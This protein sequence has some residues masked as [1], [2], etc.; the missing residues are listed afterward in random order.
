M[1]QEIIF[2]S[3]NDIKAFPGCEGFG[4]EATGGR[5]SSVV[6]FVTN[7][8]NGGAGSTEQA[9]NNQRASGGRIILRAAGTVDHTNI[10]YIGQSN[11]QASNLTYYG[12]SA[13]YQGLQLRASATTGDRKEI[14]VVGSNQI[15]RHLKSTDAGQGTHTADAM[16]IGWPTG[17]H[18]MEN[19]VLDHVS[20][21]GARSRTLSLSTKG[22]SNDYTPPGTYLRKLTISNSLLSEPIPDAPMQIIMYG[23]NQSEIS[24]IKNIL[25]NAKERHPLSNAVGAQVEWLNNYAYNNWSAHG[26]HPGSKWDIISNVWEQGPV[27]NTSGTN[28]IRLVDCDA[29]NCPPSG[30]SD[31]T[32][33]Q[34]YQT[35]NI[36]TSEPGNNATLNTNANTYS[37]GARINGG[38]YSPMAASL[39]KDHLMLNAGAGV[40]TA[41][42]RDTYDQ[43]RIDEINTFTGARP[44]GRITVPDLTSGGA[45]APYT[46]TDSDGLSDQYEL[47]QGGTTTSIVNNVRPPIAKIKDG[48]FVDQSAVPSYASVGYD[49][50]DI[51]MADLAGDW[52][53]F[54]SQGGTDLITERVRRHNIKSNGKSLKAVIN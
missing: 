25:T 27:A 52:D 34:L 6:H 35:D 30:F 13:P 26:G 24:F 4:C 33:T 10:L 51:F 50:L 46:D 12:Q 15:I 23:E 1:G 41:Q 45:G 22:G 53:A 2:L 8:N 11:G 48:R 9:L 17:T 19:I 29:S 47:D 5:G 37:V 7:T 36:D 43:A 18:P 38:T 16:K 20:L 44:T 3:A 14:I 32:G 42:G 54:P 49:H 39:I 21:R 40:G 31:Y 28:T